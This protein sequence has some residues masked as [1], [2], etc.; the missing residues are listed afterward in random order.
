MAAL[1]RRPI[2]HY[3]LAWLGLAL[4][5]ILNGVIRQVT[6]GRLLPELAAHQVSTLSGV[7]L[8]A[9]ALWWLLSVWPLADSRQAIKVGALWLCMTI[10][11]EFAFGHFVLGHSWSV[12]LADYD[13][14]KGRV[15]SLFLLWI[16]MAPFVL[17]RLRERRG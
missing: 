15:W 7:L 3:A 14:L 10:A 11:F 13:L 6:Y 16:A 17:F 2:G 12:L 8:V 4:L 5:G 1:N 9:A